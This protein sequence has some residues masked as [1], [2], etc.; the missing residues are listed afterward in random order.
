MKQEALD[1]GFGVVRKNY[2]RSADRGRF[3][4]EEVE[5]RM[6]RLTGTL[7][8]DDFADCDLVIEAV[9][10][11]MDLK[12]KIFTDLDRIVKPGAILAT[13]TS[14]LNIDEIASGDQA[15]GGCDWAAFL[16]ACERHEI[17]RDCA[18]RQDRR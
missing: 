12:K 1:R 7:S 10:E 9:F 17:A 14:A 15:P 16:L 2:Q 11:D 4:Q 5:E 18:R 3:P 6:A 8:M 13:N